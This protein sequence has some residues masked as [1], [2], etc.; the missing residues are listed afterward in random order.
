M[1]LVRVIR[2][3]QHSIPCKHLRGG[4]KHGLWRTTRFYDRT[5]LTFSQTQRC[6]FY[7]P[8]NYKFNGSKEHCTVH[9]EQRS[10]YNSRRSFVQ[11][12]PSVEGRNRTI[13]AER[14]RWFLLYYNGTHN[15]KHNMQYVRKTFF[16]FFCRCTFL[17]CT[18]KNPR[19]PDNT[20]GF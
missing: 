8:R 17:T 20:F 3:L 13:I 19:L 5:E 11:S 16:F 10:Y 4:K 7:V 2:L 9:E 6:K 14:S 1:A 15:S 18:T 12:L